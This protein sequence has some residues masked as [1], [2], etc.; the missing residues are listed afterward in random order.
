MQQEI[1]NYNH[2]LTEKKWQEIWKNQNIFK[3]NPLL[4]AQKYYV[5]EMFPYPSGKIHMGHLRN[6]TIGDVVAR[7]KKIRG[8]NVLHPMG[9]R[10]EAVEKGVHC[11]GGVSERL[12]NLKR[13]LGQQ[14]RR[15]SARMKCVAPRTQ[16][17][18]N[19]ARM[20]VTGGGA[21]R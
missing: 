2:K 7:Y 18:A 15:E 11:F 8:F 13:A 19:C 20:F 10:G 17:R 5:L 12:S 21:G 1:A 4:E 9:F 6:Y 14:G 16:H 3:F